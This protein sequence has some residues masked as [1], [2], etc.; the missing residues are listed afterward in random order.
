[1]SL[2][3]NEGGRRAD[4][5]KQADARGR[6][7][8]VTVLFAD[9]V[10]STG[11]A[12]RLEPEDFAS[13]LK[14]FRTNA[15]NLIRIHRGSIAR[16]Q[17]DGV[18]ALFGHVDPQEDD[19]RRAVE[20]ALDLS[21]AMREVAIDGVRRPLGIRLHSGIHGGLAYLTDGDIER[22]RFDVLG[23]VTNTAARLATLAAP[24][25]I[26]IS[27]GT[28]GR[29]RH[30]FRYVAKGLCP[31]RGRSQ[32]VDLLSVSGRAPLEH[33][34]DAATYR[35][36][37]RFVGRD[38]AFAELDAAA[39][40]A[41]SGRATLVV[42]CGEPGIGKTRLLE[43]FHGRL[44]RH[45]FRV[46]QGYCD[47]YTGAEPLQPFLQV[48]RAALG[49]QIG[50]PPEDNEAST[51]AALD[52]IGDAAPDD[53]GPIARRLLG[54]TREGQA[55]SP[56]KRIA[57][58]VAFITALA[59]RHTLVLVIDD[60]QWADDSSREAL[61]ALRSCAIPLLVLLSAREAQNDQD[62]DP[63]VRDGRVIA[64]RPLD[65]DDTAAAIAGWL[66]H[67]EPFVIEDIRRLS[68]GNPLFIEEL[69]HLAYASGEVRSSSQG[70]DVVWINSLVASR[71]GK[72][73]AE[74]VRYLEVASVA[75]NAFPAWV[76]DRLI[77]ADAAQSLF[78]VVAALD[79][80][81]PAEQPGLLRFK[82]LLTRDAVYATVGLE[83][84]RELHRAVAEA[85]ESAVDGD[86][87]FDWLEALS[88]HYD[89]AGRPEQAVRFAEAAGDKALAAMALDR[90]R[91][92]YLTALRSLD[93][94]GDASREHRTRWCLIAQK[95]GQ[96]CVFD[97]LDVVETMGLF[98]R[99]AATA[100]EIGDVNAVARAEYWLAYVFYGKGQPRR[101]VRHAED[102][103]EHAHASG[104]EKLVA[105][106]QATLGQAL[107]SAGR[108]EQALPLLAR[109][110]ESK[111]QQSRPGSSTAIGSAYTLAR[112]AYTLGDIGR[113]EEAGT[114][115]AQALQLLDGR[116]HAVSASIHELI[117]AVHLWQGRWREAT[118]EGLLGADIALRCR[119]RFNTAMGRAL[120]A[121]GSW[122]ADADPDAL[123]QLRES[124]HWIEAR[125]GAISM[126]LNY[127]WLVEASVALGDRDGARAA[128]ARLFARARA[129]DLQGMAMGCR[130][131]ARAVAGDGDASR[132]RHYLAIA[133]R[134]ADGRGSRRERAANLLGRA[135]VASLLGQTQEATA[136]A[137]QAAERFSTM[138]MAW[139]EREARAL[140]T[141]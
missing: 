112:T 84:R 95:L 120:A 3:P 43:Q 72:L 36:M 52:R 90:A 64:L 25:E 54:G 76:L 11:L 101:A 8:Y 136:F 29:Q 55:L 5:L 96:T 12:E 71:L 74:Q 75:G 94:C 126:S 87:A 35:E 65:D 73:P 9:I 39:A 97:V 60:W 134:V 50:A 7:R 89:A 77:G 111:R 47:S 102:A 114:H 59:R 99:A 62:E 121:C 49:W 19:G 40:E 18:L 135:R 58:I 127:G 66:P 53:F 28:L 33:S 48:M 115:F 124:S 80:L 132:A 129:Q 141:R 98:E 51:V 78:H 106:V 79:F 13:V 92:Q 137:E 105:Q 34:L 110:V 32:P 15:S 46:L 22:G 45:D 125:G 93:A 16:L 109:A 4:D 27:R 38:A 113:F 31:I 42:V 70:S 67:A 86:D 61:Q 41:A 83:R 91:A 130:A 30:F 123:R 85:L 139:H 82:H 133:D 68:G 119:S 1:M 140:A 26:C 44:D 88:Y 104:D 103:L 6:R 24:D 56:S 107:A 131:L 23:E 108:Y 14:C 20:A 37:V 81:V 10:D 116:I 117:C 128:A 100:R 17:G 118:D 2:P 21:D 138:H 63:S 69:C 57:A 122:A